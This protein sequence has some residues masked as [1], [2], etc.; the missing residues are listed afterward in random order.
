MT[1]RVHYARPG[2]VV[3]NSLNLVFRVWL[4]TQPSW[5]R[6]SSVISDIYKFTYK[7]LWIY[8]RLKILFSFLYLWRSQWIVTKINKLLA[9]I[10]MNIF[11]KFQYCKR[12]IFYW[13]HKVSCTHSH[14][15]I[16]CITSTSGRGN[17]TAGNWFFTKIWIL[18]PLVITNISTVWASYI[19]FITGEFEC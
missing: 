16:D 19:S 7:I 4:P 10:N 6:I 2:P 9:W 15:H 12:S 3:S 17:N 11:K 8:N 13:V 1:I 14:K 18:V 5:Q